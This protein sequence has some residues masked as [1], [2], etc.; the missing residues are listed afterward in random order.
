VD[1]MPDEQLV[2]R[3]QSGADRDLRPFEELMRRHQSKILANCRYLT[4]SVDDAQDLAQE[5]FVKAYFGLRTFRRDAAFGT[6][7]QRIKVNHCLNFLRKRKKQSFVDAEDPGLE[8]EESMHVAPQA[9]AEL[10]AADRRRLIEA[11]LEALPPT[12]RVALVMADLDEIPY[13]EIADRLDIGLSA[14]KMRIKR[15]R[16][17]FRRIYAELAARH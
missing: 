4:G 10:V 11:A 2:A 9:T 3:A 17:E 12:L 13:Q 6:W 14:V 16:E 8:A 5:V 15:G 7:I 1:S